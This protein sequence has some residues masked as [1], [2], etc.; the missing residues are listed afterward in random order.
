MGLMG[1]R[2]SVRTRMRSHLSIISQYTGQL[3]AVSATAVGCITIANAITESILLCI[4]HSWD[5]QQP[6]CAVFVTRTRPN[7][8]HWRECKFVRATT[9][10]VSSL[11]SAFCTESLSDAAVIPQ[12]GLPFHLQNPFPRLPIPTGGYTSP[13]QSALIAIQRSLQRFNIP[14]SLV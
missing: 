9:V 4:P 3:S 1:P 7:T 10:N 2:S 8:G 14:L 6:D 13:S 5:N 12:Q 11:F